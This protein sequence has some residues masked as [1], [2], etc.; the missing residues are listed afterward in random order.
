MRKATLFLICLAGTAFNA[1]NAQT[2]HAP[3]SDADTEE[4]R[5]YADRP[6]ERVKL[7]LKFI[8]ERIRGIE[9]LVAI[10]RGVPADRPAQLH[11][12]MDEFTRLVD[13]LQDNLDAYADHHDDIRKALNRV[14]EAD[15]HWQEA[16]KS[17]PPN[18]SYDFVQKT[19]IE[20]AASMQDASTKMI[21]EQEQY[22][23]DKKKKRDT[24]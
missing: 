6:P 8:D 3:L 24:Q 17:L 2:K 11:N 12:L 22:F 16:L 1:M 5:E 13:E 23:K 10:T 15:S 21:A 14:L 20:A 19:A 18:P 7:Y 4:L 9:S